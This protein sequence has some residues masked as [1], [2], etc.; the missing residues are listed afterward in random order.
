MLPDPFISAFPD[1]LMAVKWLG[2]AGS[3]T[4]R[5]TDEDAFDGF[6]LLEHILRER[7]NPLGKLT[8]TIN[9]RNG[10]QKW[11]KEMT[12]GIKSPLPALQ[13]QF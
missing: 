2:N 4:S 13:W 1:H 5:P 3:H 8:K 7:F 12:S 6:E 9:R 10:P 11:K